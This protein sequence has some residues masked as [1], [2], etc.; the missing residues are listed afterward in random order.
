MGGKDIPG[1][2]RGKKRHPRGRKGRS[3]VVDGGWK[4]HISSTRY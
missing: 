2:D 1:I 3:G 4:E